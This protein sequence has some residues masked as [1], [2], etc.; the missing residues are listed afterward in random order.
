M[1][2]GPD[3]TPAPRKPAADLAPDELTPDKARELID[4]PVVID[5]VIGVNPANGK[6]VV[7]K[8]GRFGP[9]V[10]ELEP[11]ADGDQRRRPSRTL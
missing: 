2:L 5:R 10:T 8:D 3:A 6:K 1:P 4:A 11:E 9:Y 7:A